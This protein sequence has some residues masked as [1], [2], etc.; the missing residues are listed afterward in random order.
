[1]RRILAVLFA[2]AVIFLGLQIRW[3][4]DDQA[5]T[6]SRRQP[7]D[8]Y[9]LFE[10][11]DGASVLCIDE[12]AAVCEDLARFDV[13]VRAESAWVT[14]ARV[15]DGGALEA[16]AWLTVRPFDRLPAEVAGPDRTAE[17]PSPVLA[18][19]PIALLGPPAALDAVDAVCPEVATRLGCAA[20]DAPE[21]LAIWDP[22]TSAFGGLA[23]ASVAF[24]L[25]VPFDA[26]AVEDEGVRQ[27]LRSIVDAARTTQTPFADAVRVAGDLVALAVEAD[28][29]ADVDSV[30]YEKLDEYDRAAVRYPLDVR[31][32]ELVLVGDPDSR[33]LTGLRDLMSSES[34]A[35]ELERRGYVA[36]GQRS[37]R[38]ETAPFEGRP[39]VRTDLPPPSLELLRDLAGL[40]SR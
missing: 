12:L 31:S 8:P 9:Q 15:L 21:R 18:R 5:Q 14:A 40:A 19:S 39:G 11:G 37:Y 20:T 28:F 25:G 34:V 26:T 36:G 7:V 10:R 6:E 13:E 22:A 27:Q 4:R 3:S 29:A 16:D 1:M 23:L 35:Y 17:A 33:H 38:F 30:D 2:V 32:V 24:D